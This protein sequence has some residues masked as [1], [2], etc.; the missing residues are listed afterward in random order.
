[1]FNFKEFVKKGLLAAV[2]RM[3]DHQVILHA[4]GWHEKGVLGEE[5]LAEI[6]AAIEEKNAACGEERGALNETQENG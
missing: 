6:D 2:G 5:E 1:M 4:A 3:A